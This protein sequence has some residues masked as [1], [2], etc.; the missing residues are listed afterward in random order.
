MTPAQP[1]DV[2]TTVKAL[3]DAAQLTMNDDEFELF[4]KTYPTLRQGADALYIPETRYE[5]P[6]LIFDASWKDLS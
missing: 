5:D 3:L 1:T 2:Q 4:V 6:A